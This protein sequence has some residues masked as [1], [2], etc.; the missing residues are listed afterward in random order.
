MKFPFAK[1]VLALTVLTGALASVGC[2]TP[3]YSGRERAQLI[4]RNWSYEGA[5]AQDDID[6]ILLLRPAS[7]LTIWHVR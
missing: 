2:S 3:V 4:A 5:Q 7:R 6:H 1:P